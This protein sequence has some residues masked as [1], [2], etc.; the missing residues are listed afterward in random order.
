MGMIVDEDGK[1]VYEE[2]GAI[3]SEDGSE[4]FDRIMRNGGFKWLDWIY[5]SEDKEESCE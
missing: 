4:V 3:F 5:D 1:L 2:E